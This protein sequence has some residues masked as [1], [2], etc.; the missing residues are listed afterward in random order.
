MCAIDIEES[1]IV[2]QSP[3]A[4]GGGGGGD[5]R[6]AGMFRTWSGFDSASFSD[7][8]SDASSSVRGG[9]VDG[10]GRPQHASPNIVELGPELLQ[11]GFLPVYA[12]FGIAPP[13]SDDNR[14]LISRDSRVASSS[15]RF[16]LD[17]VRQ[18]E[19]DSSTHRTSRL[20]RTTADMVARLRSGK[21]APTPGLLEKALV[22]LKATRVASDKD[23]ALATEVTHAVAMYLNNDIKTALTRMDAACGALDAE[24][25]L[26]PPSASDERGVLRVDGVAQR[27]SS[28]TYDRMDSSIL[29]D[30]APYSPSLAVQLR[31]VARVFRMI[32]VKAAELQQVATSGGPDSPGMLGRQSTMLSGSGSSGEPRKDAAYQH[33]MSVDTRADGVFDASASGS[34][35]LYSPPT[36]PPFAQASA[37]TVMPL[38]NP[39]PG[40]RELPLEDD[41]DSDSDSSRSN[42]GVDLSPASRPHVRGRDADALDFT[43][44]PTDESFNNNNLSS[45]NFVVRHD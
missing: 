43:Q 13:T 5:W 28:S 1:T 21:G 39:G 9:S 15:L 2:M 38:F 10:S 27:D 40:L 42:S 16:T 7:L 24:A 25:A 36:S 34:R 31:S 4:R 32:L 29:E 12:V 8:N 22:T 26:A 18:E 35:A 45:A 30:P 37:P 3:D 14:Y 17:G 23:I 6:R 33:R 20:P 11:N 44:P 41:S 19:S